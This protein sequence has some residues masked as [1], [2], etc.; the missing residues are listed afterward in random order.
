MDIQ[1]KG[2]PQEISIHVAQANKGISTVFENTLNSMR[3]Y[4]WT[5]VYQTLFVLL[6][7]LLFSLSKN[8]D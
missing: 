6:L 7:F 5:R 4:Q 2:L 3:D 8:Y 1:R